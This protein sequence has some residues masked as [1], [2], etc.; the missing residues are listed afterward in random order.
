MIFFKEEFK[1]PEAQPVEFVDIP[2]E[3]DKLV[4]I[5]PFLIANNKQ[6][7]LAA[8]VYARMTSFFT[9]LNQSY[10]VPNNKVQGLQFLDKLHEPNE[11]HLGYSSKNKG[12]AIAAERA[13]I[14]FDSLRNN[15]L[16]RQA[17]VTVTNEAHHVLLLVEGIGRDIMSDTIANVCRDIFAEFTTAQCVKHNIATSS[18]DRHYYDAV[19]KS[20]VHRNFNLPSYMGKEIILVPKI[21][22][23][24]PRN[25]TQYYNRFIAENHIAK[26][27][28][29]GSL[30]VNN[31]GRFIRTFKDG[32]RKAII[33]RILEEYRL[34]KG[35]LVEFVFKYDKSLPAFLDYAK[36][37]YPGL[38][39]SDLS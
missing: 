22:L 21:I 13:E 35:R 14:I 32:T 36:V 16:A 27:I 4:F 6:N 23:S 38:D 1:I 17:N 34:P 8:N 18:F 9:E 15:V 11:Y 29:N 31:E 37:H 20:W 39:L 26:D 10:V 24:T 7:P 28:L 19:Q 5:D 12:S 2:L 30:K 33:K 3:K 25:Y